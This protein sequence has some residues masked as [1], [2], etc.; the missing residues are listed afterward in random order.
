MGAVQICRQKPA[1]S[2]LALFAVFAAL[3]IVACGEG[4]GAGDLGPDPATVTPADAPLYAEAVVRPEGDQKD[5][6]LAALEKITNNDDPGGLIRSA[7]DSSF[8]EQGI[9]YEDDIEP[10]LGQ[11]VGGFLTEIGADRGEGAVALSVT[12]GSAAQDAIQKAADADQATETDATYEGVEY[13]V[14]ESGNAVG[15]VGEFVV[16]GTEDGLKAAIDAS[17]GGAFA[18]NSEAADALDSAPS[19]SL[20]RAYVDTARIVDLVVDAGLITQQ[21]LDAAIGDQAD[22]LQ[23]GP[24]VFSGAATADSMS[25]EVSGPGTG[26]ADTGAIVSELPAGSWIAIGVPMIGEAIGAGYESLAEGFEAGLKGAQGKGLK[27][28]GGAKLPDVDIE[29]EIRRAIGLD[30]SKDLKWAGDLGLF[31]EGSSL[32]SIGGGLVIETDDEQAAAATLVK[33]RRALGRQRDVRIITTPDGFQIQTRG[34]PLGAEVAIR[35]GKVVLAVAGT[36]VDDVLS[37]S[38]TLSDSDSFQAA[39]GAL[40]DSLDAALF[41]DFAAIVSLIEGSGLASGDPSYEEAKPILDALDY[42]IAGGG[43]DGDQ[44][45]GRLVLGLREA[46]S[47]SGAAAAI[48]P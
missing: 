46:G 37:P 20:F 3:A 17:T 8:S 24:V 41:I 27:E 22:A 43:S 21:D 32:L 44:E 36:S 38:G 25:L 13:Q 16:G 19:E 2:F 10:W 14:D 47:A 35:D 12:D 28:L 5:D 26:Q 1:R 6:L 11:R 18:D 4:A 39:S 7:V 30:L 48:V 29:A 45:L 40:G 9:S 15:I 42:L 31:V 33:L 23:E 34:A